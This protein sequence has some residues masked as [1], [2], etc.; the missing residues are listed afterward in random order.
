MSSAHAR[1]T[2]TCK[3][4][5]PQFVQFERVEDA[6]R[7]FDDKNNVAVSELTGAMPL[8]MRFKPPKARNLS[9]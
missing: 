7:A 3:R 5:P 6:Q 8:K 1:R 9:L 4:L 2:L